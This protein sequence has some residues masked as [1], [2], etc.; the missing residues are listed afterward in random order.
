[1]TMFPILKRDLTAAARRGHE[2]Q[3][4]S[5]FVIALLV[6]ASGTFGTWYYWESG[7]V[8]NQSMTLIATRMFS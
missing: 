1:M 2:S 8:T 4:R 3:S 5:V 6:A 7:H